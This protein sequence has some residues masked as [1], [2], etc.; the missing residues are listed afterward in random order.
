MKRTIFLLLAIIAFTNAEARQPKRGYRGFL[1]W[2]SSIRSDNFGVFDIHG[3]LRMER[4]GAFYTGL[5]TSHGYQINPMFYIGAGLGMERCGKLDN[6]VAPIF[7][8]G[9]IDLE[10][11]KFTPYGD[12]RLGANVAEGA[13][14]YI[15]PT[16]GYR[17]NWGRK[18][19]V[20]L[21]AGLSLAGYRSEHYEGTMTGP[22]SYEIQY[23]GTKRHIRPYFSFRLGIDF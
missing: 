7:I 20:N 12:L 3:N 11:G 5:T 22:D 6:W 13:G 18:M 15:S 9:R 1:E 23:V 16:I 17:F 10:L 21:G 4:Q 2:S 14:I 19:G 8:Q